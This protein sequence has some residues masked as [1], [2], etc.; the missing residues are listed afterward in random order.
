MPTR[1]RRSLILVF[2]LLALGLIV[3]A[4][5]AEDPAGDCFTPQDGQLVPS[6]CDA[7]DVTPDPTATPTPDSGNGNGGAAA[8]MGNYGCGACHTIDGTSLR[9]AVGPNLTHVGA[10]GGDYIRQ[11]IIDPNAVIAPDCPSGPCTSP[12]GMP[13]SF[14]T[15]IPAEE[16]D[17]IVEYLSGLQ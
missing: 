7:P 2:A 10:K 12:S 4:C 11:S 3:G 15:A 13:G 8:L 1:Y 9:G 16:L 6:D 14:G 17:Q 5:G